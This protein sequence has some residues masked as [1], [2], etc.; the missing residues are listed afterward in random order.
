MSSSFPGRRFAERLW[1]RKLTFKCLISQNLVDSSSLEPSLI[2]AKYFAPEVCP[3]IHL[4][5]MITCEQRNNCLLGTTKTFVNLHIHAYHILC[6]AGSMVRCLMPP[7]SNL[8][9]NLL[10]GC[11]INPHLSPRPCRYEMLFREN[12]IHIYHICNAEA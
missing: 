6:P 5:Q 1:R 4:S 7:Q 10:K 12:V 2:I 11:S 9:L 3:S 8:K